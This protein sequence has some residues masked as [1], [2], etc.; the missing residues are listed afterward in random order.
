MKKVK[1]NI[2]ILD[3]EG[4]ERDKFF[5]FFENDFNVIEIPYVES[6]NDLVDLIKANHIDAIAIDYNLRDHNSKFQENGDFFFK[7]LVDRIDN[8]PAFILTQDSARAKKESKR[9]NPFFVIDKSNINLPEGDKKND[10]IR[11]VRTIIDTYKKN[12]ADSI[13]RLKNLEKKRKGG[14]LSGIEESEYLELN[15]SLAK[16][17]SGYSPLPIK[18]F[19]KETNEKLDEII[20]KTDELIK[21]ISKKKG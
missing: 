21:K 3:E 10:F 5:N 20:S 6:I 4:K 12:I 19:T 17:I 13:T 14:K 1:Y 15:N 7:N 2:A 8:F 18:Y 9:I 16:S 11:E